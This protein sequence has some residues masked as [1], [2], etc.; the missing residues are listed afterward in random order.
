MEGRLLLLLA[1]N[2][3]ANEGE[4]KTPCAVRGAQ[5]TRAQEHTGGISRSRHVTS[6]STSRGKQQQ[7]RPTHHR[8]QH[9]KGQPKHH[10]ECACRKTNKKSPAG[11]ECTCMCRR[12]TNVREAGVFALTAT[13]RRK[14]QQQTQWQQHDDPR[15]PQD[16]ARR[17]PSCRGRSGRANSP[18]VAHTQ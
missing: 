16:M 18:Q 15:A 4:S 11:R 12:A 3:G 5:H 7:H 9:S 8:P 14:Q 6:A 1:I 2:T 17:A 10:L 13:R